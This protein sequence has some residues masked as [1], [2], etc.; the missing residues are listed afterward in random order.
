MRRF[1]YILAGICLVSGLAGA[2]SE[3]RMVRAIPYAAPPVGD[4]R[5]KPPMALP[6]G[7]DGGNAN[8]PAAECM[9]PGAKAAVG[10]EDCLY[11]NVWSG[12]KAGEGWPVLVSFGG[13][14]GEG[15]ALAR[16][17]IVVVTATAR[18][19][20]MGYL[21]HPDLSGE[22]EKK[23]SG[24]YGLLDQIAVLEWVSRNVA[25]F[26]GDPKKVTV[27]GT[28]AGWL[29]GSPLTKG[30]MTRAIV[31][32]ASAAPIALAEAE[33]AG[34]AFAQAE[35]AHSMRFLRPMEAGDLVQATIEEKY[36]PG[37][38][39]DGWVLTADWQKAGV[40]VQR[41]AVGSLDLGKA[42]AAVVTFVKR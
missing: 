34:E 37:P 12:A 1:G 22:S 36:A 28:P 40:E 20:L 19:G 33:K 16:Q 7:N 30:L 6:A 13:A 4:L 41:M 35:N 5:W 23:V 27:A 21:A 24:N 3:I 2:Q 38:V 8:K 25:G 32:G 39:V 11:L 10:S 17:G 29:A 42:D 31:V 26:G 14:G 18:T 9:R 15:E